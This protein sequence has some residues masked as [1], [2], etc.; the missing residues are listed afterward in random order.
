MARFDELFVGRV[1]FVGAL[2]KKRKKKS[3]VESM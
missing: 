2:K 3:P 1:E